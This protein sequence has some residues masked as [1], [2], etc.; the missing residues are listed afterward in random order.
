LLANVTTKGEGALAA[1]AGSPACPFFRSSIAVLYLS[2]SFR[3]EVAE[4]FVL[5]DAGPVIKD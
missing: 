4:Q 1:V 2:F 5:L 3:V